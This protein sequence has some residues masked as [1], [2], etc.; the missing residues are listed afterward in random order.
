[1]AEALADAEAERNTK[2]RDRVSFIIVCGTHTRC[3]ERAPTEISPE[4]MAASTS[5][6]PAVDRSLGGEAAPQ[7]FDS[8][9]EAVVDVALEIATDPSAAPVTELSADAPDPVSRPE[10]P[11]EANEPHMLLKRWPSA[12]GSLINKTS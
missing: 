7:P 1:V 6:L 2:Y 10:T 3:S 4:T 9:S 8:P 12:F 5:E 11:A